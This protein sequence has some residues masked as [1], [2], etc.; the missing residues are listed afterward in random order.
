MLQVFSVYDTKAEAYCKPVFMMNKAVALRSWI[1][2]VNDA[3][4]EINKYPADYVFFHLGSFDEQRGT[5]DLLPAPVS[6]GV[7]I[8]FVKAA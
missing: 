1:E 5:F 3:N 7:A 4:S 8:E 6:M 2:T